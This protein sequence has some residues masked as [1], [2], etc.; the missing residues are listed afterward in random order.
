MQIQLLIN[1]IAV[2]FQIKV[3][4]NSFKITLNLMKNYYKKLKYVEFLLKKTLHKS[5]IKF[6]KMKNLI[7]NKIAKQINKKNNL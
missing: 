4:V 6:I 5:M 1:R 3:R 2:S 7:N